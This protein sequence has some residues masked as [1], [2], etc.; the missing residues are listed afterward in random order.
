MY[1]LSFGDRIAGSSE[2]RRSILSLAPPRVSDSQ[3]HACY[4][5]RDSGCKCKNAITHM[6]FFMVANTK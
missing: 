6:M 5:T 1:M 3:S 2:P 4:V